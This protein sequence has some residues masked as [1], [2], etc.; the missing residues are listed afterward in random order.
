MSTVY[1]SSSLIITANNTEEDEEKLDDNE[2]FEEQYAER[3]L[4][5]TGNDNVIPNGSNHLDFNSQDEGERELDITVDG[6]EN[7]SLSGH[8]SED[9][10]P[11]V[12]DST[13]PLHII[14]DSLGHDIYQGV[15]ERLKALLKQSGVNED[16]IEEA[17]LS[18]VST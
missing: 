18:V 11:I 7:E 14:N 1:S 9:L 13:Q 2:Q 4:D 12:Q 8:N 10:L 5:C 15:I 3:N 16:L 17:C 6:S